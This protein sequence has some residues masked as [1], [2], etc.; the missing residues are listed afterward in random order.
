MLFIEELLIIILLCAFVGTVSLIAYQARQS[1]IVKM[2]A[3]QALDSALASNSKRRLQ[4]CLILYDKS[5]D[6]ETKD[7]VQSR[8]DDM[9]IE[10]D[11]LILKDRISK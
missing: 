3:H 2:Q 4:D 1:H 8:I 11:D 10:E 5:L 7:K 9:I 6:K